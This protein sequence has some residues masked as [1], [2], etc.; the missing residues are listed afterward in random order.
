MFPMIRQLPRLAAPRVAVPPAPQSAPQPGAF[1][2]P[3]AAAPVAAAPVPQAWQQPPQQ[4]GHQ[5]PT[6]PRTPSRTPQAINQPTN[7]ALALEQFP[8]PKVRMQGPETPMTPPQAGFQAL[9]MPSPEQLGI[10]PAL[11]SSA[12][13]ELDWNELRNRLRQLGAV[14]LHLDQVAGGNWRATLLMPDGAAADPRRLEAVAT[15]DASAVA[16]VL[17][18]AAR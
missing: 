13:A 1:R 7:A 9:V 16:D 8:R 3:V 2:P 15:S 11:A 17:A 12:T 4:P 14:G 5:P 18:Q 10:V 6:F